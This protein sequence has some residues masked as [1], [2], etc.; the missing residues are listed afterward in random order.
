MKKKQKEPCLGT[1]GYQCP[2]TSNSS[3]AFK[4]SIW[5]CLYVFYPEDS[6]DGMS[7]WT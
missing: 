7:Q 2:S 4:N 5:Q 3:W 1:L 6:T